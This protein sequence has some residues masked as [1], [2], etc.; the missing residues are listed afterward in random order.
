MNKFSILENISSTKLNIKNLLSELW[1]EKLILGN[2]NFSKYHTVSND[3]YHY[4]IDINV[5]KVD[6]ENFNDFNL[7]FNFLREIDI[8]F[9]ITN[10]NDLILIV[11]NLEQFL[12][13]L[14][15]FSKKQT[16]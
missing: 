7:L 2:I 1:G 13:N 16:I 3:T 12:N 11:Y 15:N 10:N 6:V 5:K 9:E 14:T 4:L 8:E